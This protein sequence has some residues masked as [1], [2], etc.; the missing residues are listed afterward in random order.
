MQLDLT[1]CILFEILV[2][3]FENACFT[4]NS[5]NWLRLCVFQS[6]EMQIGSEYVQFQLKYLQLAQTLHV[7][8]E[9]AT[10]A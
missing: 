7:S 9:V 2:I 10:I 1:M 6:K 8:V 5:C 3:G 4:L